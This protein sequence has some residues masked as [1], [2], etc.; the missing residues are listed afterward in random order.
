MVV[1]CSGWG[2]DH[3]LCGDTGRVGARDAVGMR[4]VVA[5]IDVV[6]HGRARSSRPNQPTSFFRAAPDRA[7]ASGGMACGSDTCSADWQRIRRPG[8]ARRRLARIVCMANGR[9]FYSYVSSSA[10]SVERVEQAFRNSL[11]AAVV[12]RA[13][14]RDVDAGFHGLRTRNGSHTRPYHLFRADGSN[15]NSCGSWPEAPITDLN[16]LATTLPN[17]RPAKRAAAL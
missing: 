7:A 8:I 17:P 10:G 12:H 13:D 2:S 4:V 9:A 1:V 16:A 15:G 3:R 14:A 11:S 5:G 6:E